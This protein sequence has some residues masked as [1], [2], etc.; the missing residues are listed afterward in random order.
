MGFPPFPTFLFL[1]MEWKAKFGGTDQYW[2]PE[3][4]EALMMM[5]LPFLAK[6]LKATSTKE[7]FELL[8][9]HLIHSFMYAPTFLTKALEADPNSGP[10][11]AHTQGHHRT[12]RFQFD[13]D[14]EDGPNAAWVRSKRSEREGQGQW[15]ESRGEVWREWGYCLWD[16]ERLK[17]WGCGEWN[18]RNGER[19]ER[20]RW[21]CEEVVRRS[22]RV[23]PKWVWVVDGDE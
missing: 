13:G 8:K 22:G 10:S 3:Q 11:L 6:V 9:P 2:E 23:L 16:E 21:V 19:R 14:I 20:G 18:W 12:P 5:G 7:K 4:C 1:K 15:F 17:G